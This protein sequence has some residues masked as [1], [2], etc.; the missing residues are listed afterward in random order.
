[1]KER[2]REK[3]ATQREEKNCLRKQKSKSSG[4]SNFYSRVY[5]PLLLL[6]HIF[7]LT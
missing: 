6:L 4:K 5:L 3:E 2:E 1:M 7:V